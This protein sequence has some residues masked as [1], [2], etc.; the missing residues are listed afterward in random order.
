MV[1]SV[2]TV[3]ITSA[4]SIVATQPQHQQHY[5]EVMYWGRENMQCVYV[6][7]MF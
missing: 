6:N 4:V 5:I 1:T 7:M 2:V 3:T